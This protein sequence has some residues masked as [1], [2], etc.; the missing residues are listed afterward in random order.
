M[1][2]ENQQQFD[3]ALGKAFDEQ[4]LGKPIV[5]AYPRE[6]LLVFLHDAK[7]K[8]GYEVSNL[9][10]KVRDLGPQSLVALLDKPTDLRIIAGIYGTAHNQ[11]F[12][13]YPVDVSARISIETKP[14]HFFFDSHK[15]TLRNPL[16]L[17]DRITR[18]ADGFTRVNSKYVKRGRGGLKDFRG[19]LLHDLEEDDNTYVHSNPEKGRLTRFAA[20]DNYGAEVVFTEKVC[21]ALLAISHPDI[22]EKRQRN[23]HLNFFQEGFGV[24]L[25]TIGQN[26]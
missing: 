1:V 24:H 16:S 26:Q 9:I 4:A 14:D 6:Q 19:F 15:I 2:S 23:S 22:S 10:E 18:N 17:K 7:E 11:A 21:K 13:D 5:S 25:E 12:P 8:D 20:F 3:Q